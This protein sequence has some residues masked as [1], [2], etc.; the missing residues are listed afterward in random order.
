M[1]EDAALQE[2]SAELTRRFSGFADCIRGAWYAATIFGASILAAFVEPGLT[3]RSS[4]PFA[5]ALV[6][7]H[8]MVPRSTKPMRPAAHLAIKSSR[9][10]S[11]AS[12]DTSEECGLGSTTVLSTRLRLEPSFCSLRFAALICAGELAR[13]ALQEWSASL[14]PVMIQ[15]VLGAANSP[16]S[17]R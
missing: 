10:A 12:G 4:T 14:D 16:L 9:K 15:Q 17:D 1:L 7:S 11:L 6:A 13:K 8:A 5:P 3:Q 2:A